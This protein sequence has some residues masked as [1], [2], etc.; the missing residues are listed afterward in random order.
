M[1][2]EDLKAKV[3]RAT[4]DAY[5][6]GN[7]DTLD[8]VWAP[9]FVRHQPPLPDLDGLAAYKQFI[10]DVR[11]RYADD[12]QVTFHELIEEGDWGASRWTFSGTQTGGPSPT[13]VYITMEGVSF[14]RYVEGKLVKEWAMG[15]YLGLFQQ[16][17][18]IP[19]LKELLG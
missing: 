18:L 6:K 11:K 15:D 19:P 12:I 9:D 10:L 8:E 13:V 5:H 14:L 17:G 16:D 4:E 1:S 7:V 2:T 3:R